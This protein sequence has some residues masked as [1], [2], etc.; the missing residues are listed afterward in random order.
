[1]PT[2]KE[3]VVGLLRQLSTGNETKGDGKAQCIS[4]P[5]PPPKSFIEKYL[6]GEVRKTQP[7]IFCAK[8]SDDLP[9]KELAIFSNDIIASHTGPSGG[10]TRVNNRSKP[11]E[12]IDLDVDF[13]DEDFVS[14]CDN[15][16]TL[17]KDEERFSEEPK[18]LA[19]QRRD[20]GTSSDDDEIAGIKDW[21]MPNEN[22][23]G[24]STTLYEFNPITKANAGDPIADCF[25]ICMRQNNAIIALADGV[26]WGE[27]SSLAA[28]C[29]V[30]GCMEYLNNAFFCGGAKI[31]NTSDI[32]VCLLRSFHAAHNL[33]L[34]EKAMHTTLCAA[35][36]CPIKNSEK[37][38]V[39]TCN[40]GD[41]FA[42]VYSKRYGI[43]EITQ[44]SHDIYSNRDMRDAL[45][46]LG[47]VDGQNPE[48]NNLTLSMTLVDP[49]DVVFL[50]SDGISDNFDPVVGKFALIKNSKILIR[51]ASQRKEEPLKTKPLRRVNSQ[52]TKSPTISEKPYLPRVEAHQRYELTLLRMEDMLKQKDDKEVSAKYICEELIEFVKKLTRAKRKILE[53]PELYLNSALPDTQEEQRL[54]R[55]Q[56]GSKLMCVPGKLDH[57]SIV[58]YKVDNYELD[59]SDNDKISLPD[60][61][62]KNEDLEN[63]FSEEKNLKKSDSINFQHFESSI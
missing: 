34:K 4:A 18:K 36:V 10:L 51:S 45:G 53:D 27:K 31:S 5:V 30:H 35:V 49:G 23:F 42:Y 7:D 40:V 63:V 55:K 48:L 8:S 47:P 50:T 14:S 39:C 13:I 54:R 28:R 2:L 11:F 58:A 32:F 62:R 9:V 17:L 44:G 20:S 12:R 37:F 24:I 25:G 15:I 3:K 26:N 56:A 46:A 21:N 60:L 6:N 57:A 59:S 16:S 61:S 38:A 29:A 33:I 43:R 41:S 19:E 22:A 1:M 52:L